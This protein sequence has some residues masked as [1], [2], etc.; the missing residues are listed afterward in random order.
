MTYAIPPNNMSLKQKVD[1]QFNMLY[2]ITY[3]G[4]HSYCMYL[5][6]MFCQ[7]K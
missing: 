4:I 5:N 6:T 7:A 3:F 1:K 2:Y